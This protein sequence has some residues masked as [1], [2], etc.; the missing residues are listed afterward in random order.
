LVEEDVLASIGCIGLAI[1]LI[2]SNLFA[3]DSLESFLEICSFDASFF[4]IFE[5]LFQFFKKSKYKLKVKI[6]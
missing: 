4:S 3:K 5:P 2:F 1:I 6:R